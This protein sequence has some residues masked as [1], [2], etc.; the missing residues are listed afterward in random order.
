MSLQYDDRNLQKLFAAM[1]PKQRMKALKGAFR[2]EANRVR[3]AAVNNVRASIRSNRELEKGVRAL[4]FKRKAGFRITVG[5]KPG[6]K[7]TGKGKAGYYVRQS[8]RKKYKDD[9]E[10][11][12]KYEKP[13]LM[14]ADIGTA[15]RRTKSATRIWTRSRKG[16]STGRMKRYAIIAKTQNQVSDSVTDSLH[17]EVVDS[18]IRVSKKY[19]CK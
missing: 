9:K 17:K 6:S 12:K 13:V 15:Q 2:K 4:V 19:G 1:D 14:W 11:L 3:K 16:H 18:I 5:T 7:K 8:I 10:R